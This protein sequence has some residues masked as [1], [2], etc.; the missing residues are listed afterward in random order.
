MVLHH[1]F[2]TGQATPRAWLVFLHGIYGR[3]GNWRTAARKVIA[4]RS[5]WGAVLVDLRMHG[6]SQGASPPHSVDSAAADVARLMDA[7][8]ESGKPVVALSGHSFG[9]KVALGVR[10]LAPEGLAQVWVLDSSPSVR[11]GGMTDPSNTVTQVLEMLASFPAAFGGR[12]EFVSMVTQHGF[13]AS[14]GHWL[15]MNLERERDGFRLG[16]DLDAMR[17]LLA[18]Y[19]DADMWP[20]VDDPSAESSL[21]LIASGAS[22]SVSAEDRHRLFEIAAADPR[23]F[24]D[25]IEGASHWLHIDALTALVDR[26]VRHL[27]HVG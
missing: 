11:P 23:V 9:G 14:L 19:Y 21:H 12:D 16:L 18:S 4:G 10:G 26:M 15:A 17:V 8:R 5:D 25:V 24:F 13:A 7:L 6:R 20:Q 27:P 22:D 1:T 3:G 2:V